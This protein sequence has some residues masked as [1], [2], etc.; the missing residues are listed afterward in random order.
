MI[1]ALVVDVGNSRIKWGRCQDGQ[2]SE[3]V[4]LPADDPKTWQEQ[5]RLWNLNGA[6]SWVVTGVHPQRRDRLAKWLRQRGDSV[7]ILD[8]WQQ[9]PLHIRVERPDWVGIDRLLNAVAASQRVRHGVPAVLVDAGS[10]VTVDWLDESGAFAGGAIFPGLRLM[11]QALHDYTALLP[12][13]QIQQSTPPV[14][15]TATPAAV[16]AG[17]FW[18]VAGGTQALIARL[19]SRGIV[20]P[21]VFLT[22]GD[23]PL[24]A[25]ALNQDVRVWPHMT[26]EGI[27]I[28]A[29]TLP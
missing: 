20:P 18:A 8:D 4:S 6:V 17:V 9:L 16:E 29:E 25:P 14:P 2:I 24:L 1:P 26:L 21:E 22:G 3:S 7:Q 15:A 19:S 27:R 5:L 28:A 10:A 13:I 11:T 12:L 23:A